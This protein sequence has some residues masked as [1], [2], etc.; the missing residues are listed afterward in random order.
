MLRTIRLPESTERKLEE[1]STEQ[2]KT[3]SDVI[4]AAL[5]LYFNKHYSEKTPYELGVKLF[6]EAG[7]GR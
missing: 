4:K 1:V 7:S 3:K 5:E 2:N 6:D